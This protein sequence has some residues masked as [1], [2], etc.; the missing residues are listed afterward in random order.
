MIVI[1]SLTERCNL[2][3]DYCY[4][5]LETVADMSAENADRVVDF[6]VSKTP[7]EDTLEFGF[8]GGEPFLRLD[9][10]RRAAARA[11]ER[12]QLENVPLRLRVTTNGTLLDDAAL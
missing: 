2:T 3:C 4:G 8:F 10:M 6:A 1:A 11:R 9:L 12:A 5:S 7:H